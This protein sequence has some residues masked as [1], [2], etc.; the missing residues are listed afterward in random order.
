MG[1][2]VIK[3]IDI[4]DIVSRHVVLTKHGKNYFGL[5]PFHNEKTPSFSVIPEKSL[6]KCFGCGASGDAVDFIRKIT[7]C[8][9]KGALKHLGIESGYVPKEKIERIGY[10]NKLLID[11]KQWCVKADTVLADACLAID[12]FLEGATEEELEIVGTLYHTK[13]KYDHWRE[14]LS[15]GCD[16]DKFELYTK[17]KYLGD[18]FDKIILPGITERKEAELKRICQKYSI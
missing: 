16:S 18:L 1:S 3:Q 2:T 5:C 9:F 8:D 7:G 6:F 10:E 17:K 13:E 11:F 14:V 15:H 4:V 12:L